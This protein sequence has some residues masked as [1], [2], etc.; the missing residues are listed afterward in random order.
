[1]NGAYPLR[2]NIIILY[3]FIHIKLFYIYIKIILHNILITIVIRN[4]NN[5]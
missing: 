1:M 2:Y 5:Y 3:S 4:T